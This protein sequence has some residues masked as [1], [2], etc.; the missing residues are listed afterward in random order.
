MELNIFKELI[1]NKDESRASTRC[2]WQGY[3]PS[4]QELLKERKRYP[5]WM[6]AVWPILVLGPLLLAV[7]L[8]ELGRGV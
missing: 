3:T 7:I 8:I 5:W 6:E 1:S 2:T 4:R